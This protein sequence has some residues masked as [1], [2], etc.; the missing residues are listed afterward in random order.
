MLIFYVHEPLFSISLDKLSIR[1]FE[2]FAVCFS[3][4]PSIILTRTLRWFD[5][6]HLSFLLPHKKSFTVFYANFV[7]YFSATANSTLMPYLKVGWST[8]KL[9]N[10][11][12]VY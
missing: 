4:K 2:F 11:A 1:G 9:L 5:N 7:K 10:F 12:F 6:K 8:D 3:F